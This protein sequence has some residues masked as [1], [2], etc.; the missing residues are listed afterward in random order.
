[1]N[2]SVLLFF[3]PNLFPSCALLFSICFLSI[4]II[5][6]KSKKEK[7]TMIIDKYNSIKLDGNK[8]NYYFFCE[9]EFRAKIPLCHKFPGSGNSKLCTSNM[10]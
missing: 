8:E 4:F 2:K 1:M 10:A 3:Y 9:I 6:H 7:K 5:G